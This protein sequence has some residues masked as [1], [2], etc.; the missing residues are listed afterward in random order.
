LLLIMGFGMPGAA[1]LPS[2]PLFG[3]FKS[4]YCGNRGAGPSDKPDA[5]TRLKTWRMMRAIC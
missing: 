3:G 5:R 2:L 1:W 4:I